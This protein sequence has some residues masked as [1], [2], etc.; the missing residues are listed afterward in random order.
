[1]AKYLTSTLIALPLILSGIAT[2]SAF[3]T[4]PDV[5]PIPQPRPQMIVADAPAPAPLPANIVAIGVEPQNVPESRSNVR[6]VGWKFLPAR[7]ESIA[8]AG[9][10][11]AEAA[12]IRTAAAKADRV[13]AETALASALFGVGPA[14]ASAE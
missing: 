6:V 1:M 8:L 2:A 13:V 7:D 9:R 3:G 4:T 12:D 5:A 11:A 10:D 14:M